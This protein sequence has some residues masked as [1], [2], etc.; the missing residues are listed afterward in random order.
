MKINLPFQALNVITIGCMTTY[1]N[2]VVS[3]KFEDQS[4]TEKDLLGVQNDF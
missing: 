3:K 1:T 2:P 4:F